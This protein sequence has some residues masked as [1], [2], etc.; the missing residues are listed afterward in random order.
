M[1]PSCAPNPT[2]LI[3]NQWWISG[4]YVNTFGKQPGYSGCFG[5]NRMAVNPGAFL[6]FV[7][8]LTPGTNT[9]VQTVTNRGTGESVS[10]SFDMQGQEQGMAEWVI[11]PTN[12][13]YSDAPSFTVTNITLKTAQAA[14]GIC[15]YSE[16]N[17]HGASLYCTSA[18]VSGNVC[19]IKSCSFNGGGK[20][21]RSSINSQKK[22]PNS[23]VGSS[24]SGKGVK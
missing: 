18:I 6:K 20:T 12:G 21:C 15:T 2:G 24:L 11:E 10:F 1:G 17:N 3:T 22:D 5:G 16:T 7:M 23:G 9:W 19:T 4:Q 13:W 8:E 14:P